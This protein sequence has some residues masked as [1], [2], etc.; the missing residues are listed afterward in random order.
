LAR[1]RRISTYGRS[2]RGMLICEVFS[3]SMHDERE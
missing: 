2:L 1:K 3:G